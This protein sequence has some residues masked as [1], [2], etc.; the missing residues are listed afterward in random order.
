MILKRA[1]V[2]P[3][4]LPLNGNVNDPAAPCGPVGP[5]GPVA[6]AGPVAPV[7]PVAPVTPCGPAGPAGPVAPVGPTAPFVT[8]N[9]PVPTSNRNDPAGNPA[10]MSAT[11]CVLLDETSVNETPSRYTT[12]G[13]DAGRK[14]VP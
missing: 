12:G 3:D 7:R 8:S 10:G 5:T 9:T 6:P 11:I 4:P 13:P 14:L 1:L 2:A